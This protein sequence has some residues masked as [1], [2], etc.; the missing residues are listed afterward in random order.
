MLE[1]V[2]GPD[3]RVVAVTSADRAAAVNAEHDGFFDS[4]TRVV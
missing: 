1:A 3:A 4:V 2:R